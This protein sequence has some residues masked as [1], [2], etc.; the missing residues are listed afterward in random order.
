MPNGYS[1]I[2]PII[3]IVQLE[4]L[5][6]VELGIKTI[7]KIKFVRGGWCG[8]YKNI[9]VYMLLFIPEAGIVDTMRN[10]VVFIIGMISVCTIL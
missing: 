5:I 4:A 8:D 10:Y 3:F 9:I 1:Y 7:E 6:T 2:F